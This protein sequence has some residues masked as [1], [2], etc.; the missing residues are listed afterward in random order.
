MKYR[1]IAAELITF[2]FVLNFFYEGFYKIAHWTEYSAWLHHAPLLHSVWVPLTYMIPLGQMWLALGLVLP[3]YRKNCLYIII[4]ISIVFIVWVACT[5][6]FTT[7]IS[8]PYHA[9]WANPTW[10]EKAV[11]SLLQSW[12]ALLVLMLPS[13]NLPDRIKLYGTRLN[14]D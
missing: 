7:Q 12:L 13:L 10:M 1:K 5:R 3:T 8:W 14:E 6:I 2:F 11:Q 9:A 4:C